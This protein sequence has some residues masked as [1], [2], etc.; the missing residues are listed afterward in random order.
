MRLKDIEG[1]AKNEPIVKV[2]LNML[3]QMENV[4]V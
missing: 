2:E 3:Y 4:G 1:K